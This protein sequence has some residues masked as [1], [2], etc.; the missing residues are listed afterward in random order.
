MTSQDDP[1]LGSCSSPQRD[2]QN[3]R[4]STIWALGWALS[5]AATTLLA[6]K[7]WL[8][9]P[10]SATVAGVVAT[11]LFG[12]MAVLSHR[13]Y[14]READE[15]RRKIELDALA[16]AFGV[17]L[18]GGLSYWLLMVSSVVSSEGFAYVFT[19][20]LL[21]HPLGILIGQKRYS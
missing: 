11:T 5:F 3:R 14:L 18:V 1:R 6:T 4:R 12:V 9:L 8:A 16:L 15:L 13:R 2:R 7:K 20:M 17:G 19:A 21:A 10:L